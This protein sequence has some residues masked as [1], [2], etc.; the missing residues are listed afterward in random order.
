MGRRVALPAALLLAL[1]V[2]APESGART[3]KKGQPIQ[4][5][6][7]VADTAG[8]P[9][10]G[11]SVIFEASRRGSRLSR[12]FKRKGAPKTDTLQVPTT[13]DEEGNFSFE[14]GWDSYYDT[15][16]LVVALPVRH[17]ERR[18]FEVFHRSDI[19]A[20]LKLGSPL[21]TV[22]VVEGTGYLTWL[23][24]FLKGSASDD[25]KRIFG[26]LGRPDRIDHRQNRNGD[27]ETSWWYFAQGKVYRFVAGTLD[28][29]VHF[30]PIEP[31]K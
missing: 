21:A 27:V 24:N 3:Y 6:G 14:W 2:A 20:T 30:E 29:V 9:L 22:L 11:V 5:S 28:Q 7:R 18:D 8:E 15:F 10:D 23:R 17:G 25:E 31:L 12:L 26:E 1:L 4:I 13:T 16:E 19:T